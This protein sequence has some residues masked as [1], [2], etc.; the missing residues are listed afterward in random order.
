MNKFIPPTVEE[1]PMGGHWL[2][3][4]Y[5][6]TRGISV[7][8]IDDVYYEIRT[9]SQDEMNEASVVYQGGHEYFVSDAEKADLEAAGYE[10]I[11]T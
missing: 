7:L 9:P 10:V 6:L 4:R 5:K 2:F 3:Y 11:V 8:K 1:G